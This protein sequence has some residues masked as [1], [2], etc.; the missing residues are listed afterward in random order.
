MSPVIRVGILDDHQSIVDGYAFRLSNKPNIVV[1]AT[2][3]FGEELEGML[4]QHE[5]DFLLLDVSVPTSHSNSNPYPILHE[6]PKIL[7]S[8][9]E[10]VIIIIT[11]HNQRTLI[12][13]VMQAGASGFILKD[14]RESILR[15]GDIISSVVSGGIFFS[16][17]SFK[18][19]NG[20][21][22]IET[23]NLTERQKEVLSLL[24]SQPNSTT[25]ALAKQLDIAPSTVRNLLSESYLRLRVNNKTAAVVEAR[26][27]GLIT[28]F[29]DD[30]RKL[31]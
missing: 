28:P 30:S 3:S 20:K 6:I 19:L 11:M 26:K 15:L 7:Q 2:A 27:L 21:N 5:L 22:G 4:S 24:A 16:E 13:S 29:A 8:Y 1:E 23:A 14:D 18:L 12:K 25:A 17:K 10:I 9:P 31:N